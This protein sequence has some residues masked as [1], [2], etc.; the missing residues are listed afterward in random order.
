MVCLNPAWEETMDSLL[1]VLHVDATTG[2]Y[3]MERYPIGQFFGPVDL[4][5]HFAEQHD[6]LSIGTGLLCG[7]VF[8]GSNRLVFTGKS[9]CWDGFYISSMGGAGLVF[10]NLGINMFSIRGRASSPSILYLNRTH[11]E[12]IEVEIHPVDEDAVWRGGR[13]GV[14]SVMDTAH[15]MFSGRYGEDPRVLAVGPAARSTDFG[16]V[17]SVPIEDGKLTHVDT[18]AG[19]GGF[20]SKL[21]RSHGLVGIIYGGTYVDE[22]FRDRKVANEWFEQKLDKKL[23]AADLE[24]TSK[25]RMDA[26]LQTGGT[27]GVNYTKMGGKL[28]AFNYRSVYMTEDERRAMQ[29][30]L[31]TD[32]YLKQFN[33]DLFSVPRSQAQRN[34]GEPCVAV[35]KKMHGIYKKDYEPYQALG[36]LVG[37]FDQRAAEKLNH[38]ADTMGFDGI[39]IG[40]VV[41]W[42]MDC[43]SSG[44]LSPGDLGVSRGPG[45]CPDGFDVQADSM[46]NADLG[47]E[48]IDGII[49]RRPN[50]DLLDGARCLAQRL[51]R[52]KDR[53]ILDRFVY[54]A[55]ARTGWMVPNQYW[56]PGVLSPM[57]IM[58]KYYNHYA[59]EFLPPRAL[60]RINVGRMK[61]ELILDNSGFCRFH[62]SW[63]EEMVPEIIG[64]LYGK[65]DEFVHATF[66]T[67]G[68]IGCRNDSVY[69]ESERN[70]DLVH[71]SLMRLR[72]VEGD[73]DEA[74]SMWLDRFGRDKHEAAF[75]YWFEI[76]KG[77]EE[78][79]RE[80]LPGR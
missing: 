41:A 60:G 21:R 38:H 53:S 78:A 15:E 49:E 37:V 72:D 32:H 59:N 39:S 17:V 61:K 48:I 28:I 35:C 42:L 24:A 33:E 12:E 1:K 76:R 3:R 10:D 63:A 62:R 46:A 40:G 57:P 27:L 30:G 14:Y 4:G 7:S 8:P 18:W 74:L 23:A 58:G 2:F 65:K 52:E 19:R 9:P 75:D 67:A 16:A 11:G 69:W 45:F 51:S 25:Y 44:L 68:Q 13:G 64:N 79:I 43:L 77:A 34:C 31:V 66:C 56:T 55:N 80:W 71:T 29:K 50:L 26:E 20:G 5:L 73:R 36:P 6:A 22:D 47:I 54:T 70:I